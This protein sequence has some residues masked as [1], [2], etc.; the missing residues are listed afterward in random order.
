MQLKQIDSCVRIT[1]QIPKDA[2]QRLRQMAVEGNPALRAIGIISVQLDGDS[3]ISIKLPGQEIN[4]KTSENDSDVLA[5]KTSEDLGHFAQLLETRGDSMDQSTTGSL[6][7]SQILYR[8]PSKTIGMPNS[9]L[10][11]PSHMQQH[12]LIQDKRNMLLGGPSTSSAAQVL[13]Q[14][15]QQQQDQALRHQIPQG[16][17]V[18]PLFK[19]PN[20]VCPMDGKVPVPP[21][22]NLNSGP[23]T[24]DFPFVSMRQAR[25]LQGRENALNNNFLNNNKEI[26]SSGSQILSA[27]QNGQQDISRASGFILSPNVSLKVVKNSPNVELLSSTSVLAANKFLPPPPPPYPGMGST[28]SNVINK[29]ASQINKPVQNYIQK[30][31]SGLPVGALQSTTSTPPSNNNI[32]ISSPL[33]VNLLQNDGNLL[34]SQVK[35]SPQT[36][37]QQ[38]TS[39]Q[40]QNQ[41]QQL[42]SSPIRVQALSDDNF[43]DK[44]QSE[45]QQQQTQP[46]TQLLH[47]VSEHT[48]VGSSSSIGLSVSPSAANASIRNL[49]QQQPL[50]IPRNNLYGHQHVQSNFQPNVTSQQ[51]HFLRQQRQQEMQTSIVSGGSS[52]SQHF[53]QQQQKQLQQQLSQQSQ[54][55]QTQQLPQGAVG[56]IMLSNIHQQQQAQVR[57]L[58]QGSGMQGQGEPQQ[59]QQQQQA[60]KFL[61]SGGMSP[62]ASHS[63]TSSHHSLHSPLM[64]SHQQQ[65]M[66][67]STTPVQSPHS[68]SGHA[69]K[70]LGQQ[71]QVKLRQQHRQ[72]QQQQT[73]N[74]A[75]P[76]TSPSSHGTTILHNLQV[77]LAAQLSATGSNNG[78]NRSVTNVL[79]PLSSYDPALNTAPAMRWPSLNKPMDSVT[80]SSFQE[81]AR[82]Q[83]QYN[84]QQ[85]RMDNNH[86]TQPQKQDLHQQ[87]LNEHIVSPQANTIQAMEVSSLDGVT[88]DPLITLSDFESLTTNDLD[89]LL[90]TLNCDL[91]STLTF[92]DKNELESLLQDAKDLDLDLIEENLSAVGVDIDETAAA[93]SSLLNAESTQVPPNIA[94]GLNPIQFGEQNSQMPQNI[95]QKSAFMVNS[96][97]LPNEKNHLPQHGRVQHE[98][99]ENDILFTENNSFSSHSVQALQHQ[100]NHN[101]QQHTYLLEKED[102]SIVNENQINLKE[103]TSV[104]SS[105]NQK[106]FLINPL[107][108]DMEPIES[109]D[110]ETETDVQVSHKSSSISPKSRSMSSLIESFNDKLPQSF[111]LEEDSNASS[112]PMSR[113]SSNE[114]NNA[115]TPGPGSDTERSRDSL[116]SN[117]SNR[118][119]KHCKLDCFQVSN[120]SF[121][122]IK[123]SGEMA[124]TKS[125]GSNLVTAESTSITTTFMTKTN[126]S[127]KKSKCNSIREKPQN[128]VRDKMQDVNSNP[129]ST[130]SKRT[131]G[132]GKAKVVAAPLC[133]N[134]VSTM[135]SIPAIGTLKSHP[136]EVGNSNEKIK[137]RLKLEKKEPV[138]PAYKVDVS[139][140][141]APK[142]T[143]SESTSS[144]LSIIPQ[145][146]ANINHNTPL[147]SNS[148]NQQQKQ[149][150]QAKLV[151]QQPIT[152]S[153]FAPAEILNIATSSSNDEPR[154]PPLHISLRGGKNSI[155]IKSSRKD[156][157]KAQSILS[158]VV[159]SS[160]EGEG[161]SKQKSK[162]QTLQVPDVNTETITQ[163]KIL[164]FSCSV[165]TIST[166][167]VFTTI[168]ENCNNSVPV[169]G[170]ICVPTLPNILVSPSIT[171]TPVSTSSAFV[172]SKNGL[173]ISA[174]KSIDS[175]NDINSYDNK[176]IIGST[177]VGTLSSQVI[178]Q[179]Q[180]QTNEQSVS[181]SQQ[182]AQSSKVLTSLSNCATLNSIPHN[183]IVTC[184]SD[185]SLNITNRVINSLNVKAGSMLTSVGTGGGKP[186]TKNLKPPSYLTAV[187]QLQLQKQKQKQH[188]EN[189]TQHTVVS[190]TTMLPSATTLKRVTVP[191]TATGHVDLTANA[192]KMTSQAGVN[193][194]INAKTLAVSMPIPVYIKHAHEIM[195]SEPASTV[196]IPVTNG[197]PSINTNVV[198]SSQGI[199]VGTC[200][201][202]VSNVILRN[203]PASNGSGTPGHNNGNGTGEDSGID[204]MD[205]LSEKSPNQQS[206]S[207]PTQQQIISRSGSSSIEKST[208][209]LVV[210]KDLTCEVI[211]K[212]LNIVNAN[213]K[214]P[215]QSSDIKDVT[216]TKKGKS[217]LIDYADDEI[218]KALAKMEGFIENCMDATSEALTTVKKDSHEDSLVMEKTGNRAILP[219]TEKAI[220]S[221]QSQSFVK[222]ITESDAVKKIQGKID[223]PKNDKTVEAISTGTEDKNKNNLEEGNRFDGDNN[224]E[225]ILSLDETQA[226]E[227]KCFV[228]K[229]KN[230]K[231][232]LEE[233]NKKQH[234]YPQ[235]Q[236]SDSVF[237]LISIDIPVHSESEINRI[238][239]RASNRLGSPLDINKLSPMMLMASAE[240]NAN[241]DMQVTNNKPSI[242]TRTSVH[243]RV[244]IH[245]HILN[246]G[247]NDTGTYTGHWSPHIA[248]NKRKRHECDTA[249]NS[250]SNDCVEEKRLRSSETVLNDTEKESESQNTAMCSD[251]KKCDE[252]SDSDEP[253]IEVAEK[254]RNSKVVNATVNNSE[255]AAHATLSNTPTAKSEFCQ[256]S[257]L[258]KN[259]RNSRTIVHQNKSSKIGN[260]TA[261]V[262]TATSSANPMNTAVPSSTIAMLKIVT[263][264]SSCG[265][266]NSSVVVDQ[267]TNDHNI[268]SITTSTHAHSTRGNPNVVSGLTGCLGINNSTISDEKIGTRRSV[269]SNAGMHKNVYGRSITPA[270]ITLLSAGNNNVDATKSALVTK[271]VGLHGSEHIAVVE[272]RR[273][274]RSAVIGEAQ[275]TEGR[276]RRSSRDCK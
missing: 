230:I 21:I 232:E 192:E 138:Y 31:V 135:E 193:V 78:G 71:Q 123:S 243:D 129:G 68:H 236:D 96:I 65:L 104:Y 256:V 109:D 174:I 73:S 147:P 25:V 75:P 48:M 125:H 113:P 213:T 238:R 209:A 57:Q 249:A 141:P 195:A 46:A 229:N 166:P 182:K 76:T 191:N 120:K 252:S 185:S 211:V 217:T 149:I 19:P 40:S 261:N 227:D 165:S 276:R 210:K 225:R 110:S 22:S 9:N 235:S 148:L 106:Q 60:H 87:Q 42:M 95:P 30:E 124:T 53:I 178:A 179:S 45:Q 275:L 130:K 144:N 12:Q 80:K 99:K 132:N 136:T 13:F 244:N 234:E 83:M 212:N 90:P 221:P 205:A 245:Q 115:I 74:T 134:S 119:A 88:T 266:S 17:S 137:L 63:P 160:C 11:S 201:T 265:M 139:F 107:T 246:T 216:V 233:A 35:L 267:N 242:A 145:Q 224:V 50:T 194:P 259:T 253:L 114:R 248:G 62:T 223:L 43:I 200:S 29:H 171:T 220:D 14:K 159:G 98:Y 250:S 176:S 59:N 167:T 54:I 199:T 260:A 240:L 55:M 188:F 183:S 177:N 3:V 251:V 69:Q 219:Y 72:L 4:L 127:Q 56:G 33:L 170:S 133:T 214:V 24:R 67:P 117:K 228:P 70:H 218:G 164:P 263:T 61:S 268:S 187:Q 156:R 131:K 34:A 94:L 103:T 184:S 154:V 146:K 172:G 152:F 169:L 66:S 153:S 197:C 100:S 15:Q 116:I 1:V 8:T 143:T 102:S 81:F 44:K 241:S 269:R 91:D 198:S 162:M 58:Q 206:S 32:A 181:L 239:T 79:V 157:K 264:E 111:F 23:N 16:Q 112:N 180:Y 272:A 18:Q 215:S 38:H 26:P 105:N 189:S 52:P 231:I 186:L 126:V 36:L 27:S 10:V 175:Q 51:S 101:L 142:L 247:E 37:N 93:A 20:T 226:I 273:K 64:G 39:H 161:D 204:S 196:S 237:P 97:V 203:S 41:H 28:S 122:L 82:Y 254:V 150:E 257:S 202:A 173:T 258:E 151:Q 121:T 274:T 168:A 163:E 128:N 5:A 77:P 118:S 155:V 7:H 207:S 222:P 271:S 158:S 47:S 108:G 89:A 270:T 190:V 84:L 262:S 49:Q 6:L 208:S 86:Q 255:P 92:D 85:Q 2:A 140:V